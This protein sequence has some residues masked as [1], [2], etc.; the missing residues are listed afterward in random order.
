MW[1]TKVAMK[2]LPLAYLCLRGGECE[3]KAREWERDGDRWMEGGNAEEGEL[4]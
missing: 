3:K 4:Q 2:Y 1:E